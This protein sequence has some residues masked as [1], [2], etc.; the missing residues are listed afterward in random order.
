MRT[1]T[2]T[3]GLI[4]GSFI[5]FGQ[6]AAQVISEVLAAQSHVRTLSYKLKRQDTLLT[7]EVRTMSGSVKIQIAPDDKIWGFKFWAKKDG[8]PGERVYDGN[9]GYIT[10]PS[11]MTYTSTNSPSGVRALVYSG[12]GGHLVLPDLVKLDTTKAIRTE[13]DSDNQ[14][15]TIRFHYADY[16][17]EDVTNRFKTVMIRRNTMLPVAVRNHQEAY[18]KVQDLFYEVTQIVVNEKS[19]DYNFASPDFLAKYQHVIPQTSKPDQIGA[20]LGKPAPGFS[21]TSFK[22]DVQLSDFKGKVTLIDLWEVWCGPCIASMP[23]V[24]ELAEKYKSKGLVVYG[25]TSDPRALAAGKKMVQTRGIPLTMLIGDDQ[26]RKDYHTMNTSLP[27]YLLIDQ[28]GIVQL[29][30]P[31]FTDEIARAIERLL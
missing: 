29:I 1:L 27:M 21:L 13:I 8:E 5:A 30:A 4:F 22:G 9:L 16:K 15:Y 25:I 10:I 14:F 26:F 28:N 31:G 19:F 23:K 2:L 24:V 7:G 18:G 20:L 3:I 11:N 17:P 6:S 12:G